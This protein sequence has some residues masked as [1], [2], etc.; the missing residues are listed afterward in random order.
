MML[1][2]PG[3]PGEMF[4]RFAAVVVPMPEEH[5]RPRSGRADLRR[6]WG[7]GQVVKLSNV[8]ELPVSVKTALVMSKLERLRKIFGGYRRR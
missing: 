2:P 3:L 7:W 5:R 1:I 8:N 6:R 4:R